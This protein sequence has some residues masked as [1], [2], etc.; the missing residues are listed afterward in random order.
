M[1]NKVRDADDAVDNLNEQIF[2]ELVTFMIQDPRTIQRSLLIMQISKTMERIS[3]HA[4]GMADMIVYMITGKS[5]RHLTTC[6]TPPED[7]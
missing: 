6:T 7:K 1:A 2:R 5:V 3:D 4:K